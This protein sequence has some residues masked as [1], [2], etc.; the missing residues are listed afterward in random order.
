MCQCLPSPKNMFKKVPDLTARLYDLWP[1]MISKMEYE[2][3]YEKIYF[4]CECCL[5]E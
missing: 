4:L 5:F 1:I 2:L 3:M